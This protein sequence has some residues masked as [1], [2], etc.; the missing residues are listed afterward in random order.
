VWRVQRRH[1][2][3]PHGCFHVVP[4]PTADWERA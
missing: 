2:P 4:G 1:P 3:E